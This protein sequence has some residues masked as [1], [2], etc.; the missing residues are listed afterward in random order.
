MKSLGYA[1]TRVAFHL[2]FLSMFVDCFFSVVWNASL[3]FSRIIEFTHESSEKGWNYDRESNNKT[4]SLNRNAFIFIK[5]NR[6]FVKMKSISYM[7]NN[8]H[9]HVQ[10][11]IWI[12]LYFFSLVIGNN[13]LLFY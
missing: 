4:K 8:R 2:F 1:L 13:D 9:A 5:I 12:E 10:S 7:E 11:A 3:P 6:K